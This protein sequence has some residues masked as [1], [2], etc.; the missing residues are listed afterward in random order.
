MAPGRNALLRVR[1]SQEQ[2]KDHQRLARA[3][4]CPR[5]FPQTWSTRILA[6]VAAL[7]EGESAEVRLFIPTPRTTSASYVYQMDALG[8]A[9]D[10]AG[11][12]IRWKDY[13]R[14]GYA[15]LERP[16]AARLD[17]ESL[18]AYLRGEGP[19][20]LVR[21]EP[22]DYWRFVSLGGFPALPDHTLTLLFGS[23]FLRCDAQ[24]VIV[25]PDAAG[26]YTV[27]ESTRDIVTQVGKSL[28]GEDFKQ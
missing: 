23:D 21:P 3:L 7:T 13:G 16:K 15:V 28:F 24:G 5:L 1:M 4:E 20:P 9:V 14:T 10:T 8:R 26:H 27:H 25:E 6:A 18:V 2:S 22:G 17:R 12:V 19:W 11:W